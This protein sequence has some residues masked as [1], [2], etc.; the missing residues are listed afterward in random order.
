LLD[1]WLD[2]LP[3]GTPVTVVMEACYSG[4]FISQD[5]IKS[6]LGDKD[7]TIIVSASADKQARIARSSS[8]SRTFFNLIESNQPMADAF[9]QAKD[10][11][12][13]MVYHQGQSATGEQW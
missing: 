11:L 13:R 7:R 12:E 9:E 10:K 5:G 4:N 8:F 6:A 3:A 2:Q 1:T